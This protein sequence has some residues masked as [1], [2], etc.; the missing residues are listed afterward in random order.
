MK[1]WLKYLTVVLIAALCVFLAYVAWQVSS[2]L[3]SVGELKI[4]VVEDLGN[5]AYLVKVEGVHNMT[6]GLNALKEQFNYK[7]IDVCWV[8]G[9]KPGWSTIV[10]IVYT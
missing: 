3:I 9:G 1:D 4:E 2:S 10:A 7:D 8:G 5:G 6:E